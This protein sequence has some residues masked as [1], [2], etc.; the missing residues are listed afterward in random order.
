MIRQMHVINLLGKSFAHVIGRIFMKDIIKVIDLK[1][2]LRAYAKE[3]IQPA[4][5]IILMHD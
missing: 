1:R 4:E 2:S 5:K 3:W